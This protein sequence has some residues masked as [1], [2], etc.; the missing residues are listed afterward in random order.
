MSRRWCEIALAA[1]GCMAVDNRGAIVAG[2]YVPI[3]GSPG[4][5]RLAALGG[6]DQDRSGADPGG[7]D[8]VHLQQPLAG[9]ICI[10]GVALNFDPQ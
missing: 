8:A 1:F 7:R 5:E 2:R 3:R 9:A 6:H 4:D 10:N